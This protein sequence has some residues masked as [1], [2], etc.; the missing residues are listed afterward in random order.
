MSKTNK[1]EIGLK[2]EAEAVAFLKKEGYKII[3][4]NYTCNLGE[5]DIIAIHK[6]ILVFVE[7][8]VRST[9]IFGAPELAVTKHKRRQIIRVAE[10]YLSRNRIRDTDCR[11]DVVAISYSSEKKIAPAIKLLKNAFQL[12][13][14]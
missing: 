8:K 6:K 11:F 4:K 2:G 9:D 13:D 3:K 10:S 7:V 12:D 1:K 5:I 14:I